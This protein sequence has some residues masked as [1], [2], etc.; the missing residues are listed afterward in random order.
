[1]T[2][3]EIRRRHREKKRAANLCISCGKEPP[4]NESRCAGC[5]EKANQNSR[6]WKRANVANGLCRLCG[7][8]PY[9]S[10][11]D[12]GER[13]SHNCEVCY[14]KIVARNMLGSARFLYVLLDKLYRWD[15]KCA[16]AGRPLVLGKNLSFDHALPISRYPDLKRDPSNLVPVDL[17]VNFV[18]RN[19]TGDEF[20]ALAKEIVHHRDSVAHVN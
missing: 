9:L 10:D 12:T 3:A 16:Y 17:G 19:L 6:D 11:T 15:W 1:M 14:L 20:V 5:N 4:V 18:K 2:K 7:A 13:L 8:R